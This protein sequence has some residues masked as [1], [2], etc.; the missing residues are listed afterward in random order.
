MNKYKA[1]KKAAQD[2]RTCIGRTGGCRKNEARRPG[3]R[4]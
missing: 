2:A 4:W 1:V 3:T